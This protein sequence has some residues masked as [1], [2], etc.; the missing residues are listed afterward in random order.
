MPNI[1]G[2]VQ[3][4]RCFLS[5]DTSGSKQVTYAILQSLLN[6]LCPGLF[7]AWQIDE[8][9]DHL[10]RSQHSRLYNIYSFGFD[11]VM[12]ILRVPPPIIV[13]HLLSSSTG[14]SRADFFFCTFRARRRGEDSTSSTVLSVHFSRQTSMLR[15]SHMLS[16]PSSTLRLWMIRRLATRYYG[17]LLQRLRYAVTSQKLHHKISLSFIHQLAHVLTTTPCSNSSFEAAG[18]WPMKLSSTTR[19]EW[20]HAHW[21]TGLAITTIHI[22]APLVTRESIA[23]RQG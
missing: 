23:A 18:N 15:T 22:Q 1:L 17:S 11:H 7:A 19:S 10:C 8:L 16:V 13:K 4:E 2:F 12:R 21:V 9:F 3:L 5:M 6:E 20:T 14:P